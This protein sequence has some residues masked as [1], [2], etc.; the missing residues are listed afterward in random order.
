MSDIWRVLLSVFGQ[1]PKNNTPINQGSA[2]IR[3]IHAVKHKQKAEE[4]WFV[5]TI[6][7]ETPKQAGQMVGQ[8]G[9]EG[10]VYSLLDKPKILVKIYHPEKLAKGR[11]DYQSKIDAMISIK[12]QF[13]N[14]NVCW[15]LLSVYDA[16]HQWIGYAMKQGT[17]VPMRYLAHAV[18]YKKYFQNLN[19]VLVLQYLLSF[20]KNI[21]ML[22]QQNVFIGDYNL[23]NFL[24]DSSNNKVTMIDSDSYQLNIS[25]KFFPCPV[26]SADLTPIEHQD[27]NFKD[28]V[29]NIKSEEFSVAI[30][31]FECLM[32]GRHPYDVVDGDDPVT[33]L[34]NGNFPYGKGRGGYHVIP[35]GPWYNIWSHMPFRVKS[36]FIQTFTDGVKDPSKRA[37][38]ND[39]LTELSTYLNEMNR[40]WHNK[41]ISPMEPK[42]QEYHGNKSV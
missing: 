10:T 3:S 28:V 21:N 11:N 7:K 14:V 26:G 42:K 6:S 4:K 8:P 20:L 37:S 25:N 35:K 24:C 32:L 22:H 2:N 39:W 9:G 38:I 36:L 33:N 19:R 15:P 29:R 16:S 17:G 1:T 23:L 12:E 34:R 40:G 31:I 27:R 18:A 13:N 41:E 30:I 5:F